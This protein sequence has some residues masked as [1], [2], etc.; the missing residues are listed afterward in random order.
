MTSPTQRAVFGRL[1]GEQA[2]L[3]GS[4]PVFVGRDRDRD[5]LEQLFPILKSRSVQDMSD[6]EGRQ[7][8]TFIRRIEGHWLVV[9]SN[10]PRDARGVPL[11]IAL[12]IDEKSITS[13]LVLNSAIEAVRAARIDP[14][15]WLAESRELPIAPWDAQEMPGPLSALL[16]RVRQSP[17]SGQVELPAS[18][19]SSQGV[20]ALQV[21]L[22]S[23]AGAGDTEFAAI[24]AYETDWEV[25]PECEWPS[26]C[27]LFREGLEQLPPSPA[28]FVRGIPAA[29][30][31]S[32]MAKTIDALSVVC[33]G[34]PSVSDWSLSAALRPVT[35]LHLVSHG[36]LEASECAKWAE[37]ICLESGS[38]MP[39]RIKSL[40]Q[41]ALGG[42][43]TAIRPLVHLI[44]TS[45]AASLNS[46]P[47]QIQAWIAPLCQLR[48]RTA[49][50]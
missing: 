37:A 32:G 47:R 20:A 28:E 50:D 24:I 44:A 40:V 18:F 8:A 34:A 14:A 49:V 21:M 5:W 33:R 4:S 12:A 19:L 11:W 7:G 48:P 26:H 15:G 46:D 9:H 2:W 39:A 35:P 27:L 43:R 23:T 41:A 6:W 30:M 25:P 22:A 1:S 31:M 38:A 17:A 45:P 42:D 36:Q 13:S 3:S 29:R 10:M 16:A